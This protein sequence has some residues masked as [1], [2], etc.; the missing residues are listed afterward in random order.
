[1]WQ[2]LV[3]IC[4][5]LFWKWLK[6]KP[7]IIRE[8]EAQEKRQKERA[9]K[10]RT[11]LLTPG[12]VDGG[13]YDPVTS[14]ALSRFS[15]VMENTKCPFARKAVVWGSAPWRND[16][17]LEE[18]VK[19]SLPNLVRF[20]QETRQKEL[21]GFVFEIQ[22]SEYSS[23]VTKFGDTVRRVLQAITKYDP[24]EPFDLLLPFNV[25]RRGWRYS[26]NG[27]YLFITAFAPC[28]AADS[29]RYCY[30]ACDEFKSCFVLLQ[31]ES[32]FG[33]HNIGP[34]HPWD[35][36]KKTVRQKIRQSFKDH[37]QE[38]HVPHARFFPTA[39]LVVPSIDGKEFVEWWKP[40]SQRKLTESG[41]DGN[42]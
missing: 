35:D 5:F 12:W 37:G 36:T 30:G 25:G 18:N 26:W 15:T 3:F 24:A 28:Y 4:C 11:E 17:S 40:L 29:S 2:V 31:P 1:M 33:R 7:K 20:T 16:L 10:K 6:R 32:S 42:E 13:D 23:D 27:E 41:N 39:R 9:A 14:G 22:G 19:Q 8:L 38:Y 21:D 34:D